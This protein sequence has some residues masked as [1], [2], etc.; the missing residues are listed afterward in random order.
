MMNHLPSSW[1]NR[2][3]KTE[4]LCSY[5]VVFMTHFIV[6]L[7][8]CEGT[9]NIFFIGCLTSNIPRKTEKCIVCANQSPIQRAN[10]KKAVESCCVWIMFPYECGRYYCSTIYHTFLKIKHILKMI[11]LNVISLSKLHSKI[12]YNE[13]TFQGSMQ[14]VHL[15]IQQK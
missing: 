14:L 15:T 9:Q 10:I 4:I 3:S 12:R 13:Q 11:S 1:F 8:V 6:V 7:Q 5:Q 2:A